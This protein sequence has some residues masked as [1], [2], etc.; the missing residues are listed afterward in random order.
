MSGRMWTHADDEILRRLYH[1]SDTTARDIAGLLG[2]TKN[3]VIARANRLGLGKSQRQAEG[4]PSLPIPRV[5]S[6]GR[7]KGCQWMDGDPR[8]PR[9]KTCGQP[10]KE[11]SRFSYCAQHHKVV[12]RK[13]ERKPGQR[14]ELRP[15]G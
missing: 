14:F 13:A 15:R 6:N 2:V 1:R 3:S 4:L 9:V 12:F 7:A 5:G 11:G 8:D 10:L